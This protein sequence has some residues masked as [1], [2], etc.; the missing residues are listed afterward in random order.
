MAKS[1]QSTRQENLA[2]FRSGDYSL[3]LFENLLPVTARKV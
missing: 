2:G 1:E 3:L